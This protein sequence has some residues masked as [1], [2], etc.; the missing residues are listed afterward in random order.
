MFSHPFLSDL[1][2]GRLPQANTSDSSLLDTQALGSRHL[3]SELRGVIGGPFEES[4]WRCSCEF[5]KCGCHKRRLTDGGSPSVEQHIHHAR[6]TQDREQHGI[7]RQGRHMARLQCVGDRR[8][9]AQTD[10][11]QNPIPRCF[12]AELRL[13]GGEVAAPFSLNAIPAQ[14]ALEPIRRRTQWTRSGSQSK[15]RNGD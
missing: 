13:H 3:C 14:G 12:T 10:S 4:P 5:R 15:R 8:V 6:R 7:Q 9:D 11:L 1:R 2:A